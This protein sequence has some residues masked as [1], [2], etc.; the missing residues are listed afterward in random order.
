MKKLTALL[1]ALVMVLAMNVSALAADPTNGTISG[2]VSSDTANGLKSVD[3]KV[4]FTPATGVTTPAKTF[5]YTVAHG[6]A[7]TNSKPQVYAGVG[8]PTIAD[9]VFAAGETEKNA[10]IDLSSLLVAGTFPKAG[11]YRYSITQKAFTDE[12]VE[13]G[14]LNEDGTGAAVVKYLDL[15]VNN[16]GKITN[17]VL[18]EPIEVLAA[19]GNTV[20]YNNKT[21]DFENTYAEGSD[22]GTTNE[23][24]KTHTFTLDKQVAGG[25]GNQSDVFEFSFKAEYAGA[26]DGLLDGVTYT[27]AQSSAD[28]TT[29]STPEIGDVVTL[30]LT[31]NESVVITVPDNVKVTVTEGQYAT[32]EGYTIVATQTGAA[33]TVTAVLTNNSSDINTPDAGSVIGVN[34]A[35]ATMTYTNTRDAISPTG[36]VLRIAPY[37]IMLGAGIVLFIILKSRKNK[38]VEEA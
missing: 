27:I 17:A 2:G 6:E 33:P 7:D 11:V 24:E 12:E 15:Y 29:T 32:D 13:A 30:K 8:D 14:F 20:T 21:S 5:E 9:V 16:T 37:A 36:V 28:N 10:T 1:L 34:D 26:T 25:M 18:L 35:D 19:D 22:P 38:A 3:F 31:H 4:K 23:N